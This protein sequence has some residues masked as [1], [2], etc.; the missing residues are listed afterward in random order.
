MDPEPPA[1]PSGGP[2][3]ATPSYGRW[4]LLAVVA[5][6]VGSFVLESLRY[7]GFYTENWD[8]G[9]VQQALWSGGHGHAFWEAG[10]YETLGVSSL[11]Q[12]HPSFVLF[13]LAALYLAAPSAYTLF[14]V[15]SIAVGLGAIPL[16]FLAEAVTSSKRK[17]AWSAVAYLV[18]L[19][20]LTAQLYDFHFEAFLPVELFAMFLFWYRGKY[21]GA[22]VFAVAAMLTLE[23]APL[24]V[25]A[26]ALFFLLPPLRS[27][28]TE[29]V[30]WL[31]GGKD[32][33]GRRPLAAL[34]SFVRRTVAHFQKPPNLF[35]LAMI[36][37]AVLVYVLLRL[38]Q[39]PWI[40]FLF[41]SQL[42]PSGNFWGFSAGSLGLS[43]S[44]L[45]LGLEEKIL[46][47]VE[48]FAL[49]LF[50]PLLRPRTLIITAPWLLYTFLSS[51]P[52]YTTIG[53]QYGLV[54]AYPVLVGFVFGLDRLSIVPLRQAVS[55]LVPHSS[56]PVWRKARPRRS[57]LPPRQ[58][59][60]TFGLLAMVV[61]GIVLSPANPLVQVSEIPS[62]AAQGYWD[63]YHIPP[64]YAKVEAVVALIP[65]GASL[66]A[67][68][69]LFPFVANDE[70]A[71]STLWYPADP[72]NLPFNATNLPR[73]VLISEVME[74]YVPS[75][76]SPLLS[77]PTLFGL[78]ALVQDSP[79]GT[80]TLYETGFTGNTTQIH[81]IVPPPALGGTLPRG[82]IEP[83]GARERAELLR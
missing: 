9:I 36:N 57:S 47:W 59:A 41:G 10:D 76:L 19:P 29:L 37:L 43:P 67:S 3:P 28:L 27:S 55:C 69:D 64:A 61:V 82:A 33:A 44:N 39:G 31:Q 74:G 16:Y 53:F 17:A 15:Q 11:F 40:S 25:A 1:T 42:A 20:L 71:Y 80:I 30:G 81:T 60:V 72:P 5:Y 6:I 4:L 75:W 56:D 63:S 46:Y 50:I 83:V 51:D 12:V 52:A 26:T 77:E 68:P 14:A 49:L 24:F 54:A 48:I 2:G 79:V 7:T 78:R 62:S 21:L 70:N 8:L 58:E 13:P 38:L 18:W 45:S 23:V 65:A 34:R 22:T 32:P 35:A 66:I 73:F